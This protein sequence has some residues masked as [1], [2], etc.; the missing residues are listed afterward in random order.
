MIK[1]GIAHKAFRM[2]PG[3]WPLDNV[4]LWRFLILLDV[5]FFNVTEFLTQY[6]LIILVSNWVQ[7]ECYN[8]VHGANKYFCADKK[9]EDIHRKFQQLDGSPVFAVE[10]W[11]GKCK[12]VLSIP[13]GKEGGFTFPLAPFKFLKFEFSLSPPHPHPPPTWKPWIVLNSLWLW[14]F[15]LGVGG[16]F[17]WGDGRSCW[18]RCCFSFI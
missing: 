7:V 1:W 8:Y 3:T 10:F 9:L 17:T 18:S 5:N 6:M 12:C 14:W 4:F 15:H 16:M 11:V 13:V 2:V